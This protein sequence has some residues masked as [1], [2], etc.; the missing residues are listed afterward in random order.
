M[1]F[2]LF[3]NYESF[4]RVSRRYLQ[5][6][7]NVK[8]YEY[9]LN[10]FSFV[11]SVLALNRWTNSGNGYTN[12]TGSSVKIVSSLVNRDLSTLSGKNLLH[13]KEINPIQ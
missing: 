4:Q 3:E 5:G 2:K 11:I 13:R 7:V 12:R 1:K 10:Y 9:W 6:Y 8:E